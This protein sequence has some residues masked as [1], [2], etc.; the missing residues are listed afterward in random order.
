MLTNKEI[1]KRI[2]DRRMQLGLS[3]E[4]VGNRISMAKTTVLRYENGQIN[5]IK[6]VVIE[7]MAKALD[8]NPSWLIGVVDDPTPPWKE[9][10]KQNETNALDADLIAAFHMAPTEIQNIVLSALDRYMPNKKQ[11][12]VS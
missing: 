3:A 5:R 9:H 6:L 12:Q 11:N 8:C 1:G 10:I 4:Q 7:A 2:R